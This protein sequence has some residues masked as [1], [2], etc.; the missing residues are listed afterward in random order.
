MSD[1]P[2]RQFENLVREYAPRHAVVLGSGLGDLPPHFQSLGSFSQALV[3]DIP[4][5]TVAGHSGKID[6]GIWSG[7]PILICQGRVHSYE[8]WSRERVTALVRKLPDW[9]INNLLLFNATGGIHRDLVPGD[10]VLITDYWDAIGPLWNAPGGKIPWR[11][12]VTKGDDRLIWVRSLKRSKFVMLQGPCYETPAEIR[13]LEMLGTGVVGMSS[14]WELDAAKEADLLVHLVSVIANHACGIID[15][16]LSHQ[17]VCRVM[18][19]SLGK[20]HQVITDWLT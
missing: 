4:R 6:L 7:K 14:S 2:R 3:S 1:A 13:A 20:I 11:E 10:P 15:E 17:D 18:A 5:G 16:P 19:E 8:G 9:G 12:I